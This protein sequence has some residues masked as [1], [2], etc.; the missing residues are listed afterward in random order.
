MT[1]PATTPEQR[2]HLYK[3]VE[4]MVMVGFMS[5]PVTV[6]KTH[7]C[8]RS[9][10]EGDLHLLRYRAVAEGDWEFWMVAGSVWLLD[11]HNLLAEPHA[12]SRVGGVLRRLPRGVIEALGSVAVGLLRRVRRARLY[13]EAFCYEAATRYLWK[14]L[15]SKSPAGRFGIPGTEHMGTNEVQTLWVAYNEM[16][17]FRA[18]S[19]ALWE[20]AKLIASS[21]APKAVQKIDQK[22]SQR[23]RDENARRQRVMDHAFYYS[24]GMVDEKGLVKA[25]VVEGQ[26]S[27]VHGAQTEEEL[28]EEM[29]RWVEGEEDWHDRVVSA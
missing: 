2:A 13:T 17:D 8:L 3:D 25:G 11:G 7:L 15:G 4:E 27:Y 12:A 14:G 28:A 26:A 18:Q 23:R 21:N 19:D 1:L 6:G 10:T 16:E 29:R 5:H 24:K 20:A 9:L 22:E